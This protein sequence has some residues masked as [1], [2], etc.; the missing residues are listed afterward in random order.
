MLRQRRLPPACLPV[1]G[2]ASGCR[3]GGMYPLSLPDPPT[4]SLTTLSTICR[5]A[6]SVSRC[7]HKRT[8]EGLFVC[9]LPVFLPLYRLLSTCGRFLAAEAARRGLTLGIFAPPSLQATGQM[10]P[11]HSFLTTRSR[12]SVF[13]CSWTA[14][15]K[16][17]SFTLSVCAARLTKTPTAFF[18]AEVLGLAS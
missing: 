2:Q 5:R 11:R 10:P 4:D 3:E 7:C 16:S 13:C 8:T 15:S 18:H 6:P 1:T 12:G 14:L 9:F 17:L